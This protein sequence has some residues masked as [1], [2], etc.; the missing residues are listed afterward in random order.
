MNCEHCDTRLYYDT[1]H[2]THRFRRG[3]VYHQKLRYMMDG[4]EQPI[5]NVC[6]CQAY[7][8]QESLKELKL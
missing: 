4:K 2:L 5:C 6:W 8:A 1:P 7:D 3:W